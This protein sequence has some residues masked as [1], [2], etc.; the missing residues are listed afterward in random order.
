MLLR[1]L[2]A[3][4]IRA[5]LLSV[6]FSMWRGG[7]FRSWL[8][9][10]PDKPPEIVFDNGSVRDIPGPA[11]SSPSRT[12]A[13]SP[14]G[15]MRKCVRGDRVTYSNLTCPPGFREKPVSRDGVTVLPA[16]GN[17]SATRAQQGA[18]PH[19]AMREALDLKRDEKLRQRMIDRAVEAEAR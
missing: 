5:I 7:V 11:A 15:V 13:L 14:P 16:D 10:T 12:A 19:E 17:P 3:I 8:T 1:L 4:G 9:T 2:A 18:A 6:A